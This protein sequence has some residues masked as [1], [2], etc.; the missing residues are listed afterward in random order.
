MAPAHGA[1]TISFPHTNPVSSNAFSSLTDGW[2]IQRSTA[3]PCKAQF[4]NTAGNSACSR[5]RY[6]RSHQYFFRDFWESH[7]HFPVY[8]QTESSETLYLDN[9]PETLAISPPCFGLG[10]LGRCRCGS[11]FLP[12]ASPLWHVQQIPCNTQWHISHPD[13]VIFLLPSISGHGG[14][15]QIKSNLTVLLTDWSA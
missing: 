4:R 3:A 2:P 8:F 7:G 10:S 1:S 15:E 9:T 13:R 11:H 5:Q 14:S 6:Q 12:F